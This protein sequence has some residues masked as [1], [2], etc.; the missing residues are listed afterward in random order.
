MG[1][2][3]RYFEANNEMRYIYMIMKE[4]FYGMKIR[5]TFKKNYQILRADKHAYNISLSLD[6]MS[7]KL[8]FVVLVKKSL[9]RDLEQRTTAA[10]HRICHQIILWG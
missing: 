9:G 4:Q 7:R 10:L 3:L 2:I 5:L 8:F 1:A 6:K